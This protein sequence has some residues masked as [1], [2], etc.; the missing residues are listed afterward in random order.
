MNKPENSGKGGVLV[1]FKQ[2][3]PWAFAASVAIAAAFV[4]GFYVSQFGEFGLSDQTQNW[5]AFGDY[6]GGV[7]NP[8]VA[9]AALLLLAHSISIQRRELHDTGVALREQASHSRDLVHLTAMIAVLERH[10]R[11]LEGL[12]SELKEMPVP[13]KVEETMEVIMRRA[14]LKS[15]IQQVSTQHHELRENIGKLLYKLQ[16]ESEKEGGNPTEAL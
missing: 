2:N 4:V 14:G 10:E 1:H 16:S 11:H 7:L 6:V 13:G 5:G 8:L 12:K 15:A 3:W 9:L